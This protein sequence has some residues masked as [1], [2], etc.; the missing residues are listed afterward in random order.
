[1]PR[2][3]LKSII[4]VFICILYIALIASSQDHNCT[5]NINNPQNGDDVEW[6]TW[7]RGSLDPDCLNNHSYKIYVLVYPFDTS[8]YW[9]QPNSIIYQNGSW[10]V[11]SYFGREGV[12]Y[13]TWYVV[14][15][16][17]TSSKFLEGDTFREIPQHI[18]ISDPI[19]V[20]RI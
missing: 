18:A 12:D 15:A 16:I 2:R 17:L 1:M 8:R 14:Y 20:R 5:L 9:V 3:R 6:R 7:I 13:N 4:V 10:E 19:K 11:Y